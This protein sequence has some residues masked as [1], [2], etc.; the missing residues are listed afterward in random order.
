M[1]PVSAMNEI[2]CSLLQLQD[3]RGPCS[4]RSQTCQGMRVIELELLLPTG[5]T[6]AEDQRIGKLG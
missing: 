1:G 3:I 2:R 5:V 4:H 6:R